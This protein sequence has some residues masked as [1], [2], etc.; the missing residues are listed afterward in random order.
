MES[1]AEEYCAF[2]VAI[3]IVVHPLLALRKSGRL[4]PNSLS[5]EVN[6]SEYDESPDFA[7]NSLALH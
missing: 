7:V 3:V 4:S 5:S 1:P 6:N 2:T